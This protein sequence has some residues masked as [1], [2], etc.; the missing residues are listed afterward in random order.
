MKR[1]V[2]AVMALVLNT[3]LFSCDTDSV[4]ESDSLYDTVATEGDDGNTPPPPP[5]QAGSN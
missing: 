1:I 2:I 3:M 4:A 5:P